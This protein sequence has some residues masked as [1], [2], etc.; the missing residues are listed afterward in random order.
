VPPSTASSGRY[1]ARFG[2]T[3]DCDHGG[4]RC[5]LGAV[6]KFEPASHE[7]A[8]LA[9]L[10]GGVYV[11]DVGVVISRIV[12]LT[13]PPKTASYRGAACTLAIAMSRYARSRSIPKYCL[14]SIAAARAVVP[15][16]HFSAAHVDKTSGGEHGDQLRP[17]M[18][19]PRIRGPATVPEFSAGT[20]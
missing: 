13:T 10:H 3:K 19:V 12:S 1:Q 7:G 2:R 8:F 14:P 4:K 11:S 6:A 16:P 17:K 9:A 20:R 18:D 5:R 15:E